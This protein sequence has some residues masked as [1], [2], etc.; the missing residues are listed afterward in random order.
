MSDFW[1]I[2]RLDGRIF[3]VDACGFYDE[4]IEVPLGALETS[5]NEQYPRW[6]R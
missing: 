5:E 6:V 3:R 4:L 1:T 2:A